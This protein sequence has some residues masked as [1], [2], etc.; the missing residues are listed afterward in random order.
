MGDVIA[1]LTAAGN[2]SPL[3][4]IGFDI[5]PAQFP[6]NPLPG[7]KFVVWD[8]TK[9]FPEEYHNSFDLVH[10]RFAVFALA[11]EQIQSVVENLLKLI[12][13]AF[14]SFLGAEMRKT[15]PVP[16]GCRT[17]WIPSMDGLHLPPWLRE[18]VPR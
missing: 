12:S 10:I 6:K 16:N 17:W 9:E 3:E 4:I 8:M 11:I 13:E 5:S 14:P 1:E 15:F 7:T 2:T 18:S